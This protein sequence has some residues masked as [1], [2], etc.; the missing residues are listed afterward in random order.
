MKRW[1]MAALALL[2]MI[3]TL[4][5]Q[6]EPTGITIRVRSKD[7]KFVG[8]SMGG[9]LVTIRNA[10]TGELLAKGVTS[11]TTGNSERLITKPL[12]RGAVLSDE[13]SAKFSTQ[14]DLTEPTLLEIKAYGPLAQRRAAVS[15]TV[16]Q[17]AVPG[18]HLTGGDG[19]LLELPGL[20]LAVLAPPPHTTLHPEELPAKVEI[21]VNLVMLCGCSVTPG[22]LWDA[23]K[24]EVRAQVKRDGKPFGEIPLSY[25][26]EPSI[27]R[28]TLELKEPAIYEIVVYAF[29]PANGNTGVDRTTIVVQP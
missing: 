25:S 7:A 17:W 12:E 28:G 2:A 27:F 4:P 14:L 16:T 23:G 11:G 6:A 19:V 26:G 1:S 21:R 10:D 8:T 22:G 13:K 24:F 9:A 3:W 15:T 20:A 29:D 18:K 5:A